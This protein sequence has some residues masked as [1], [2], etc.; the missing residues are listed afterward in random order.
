MGE[1][2]IAVGVTLRDFEP[3]FTTASYLIGGIAFA[4]VLYWSYFDRALKIWERSL[5][6]QTLK[7]AGRFAVDVYTFT[8][9]ALIIG[10]VFS[11]VAMEEVFLHP[12]DPLEPFV[13]GLLTLAIACFFGGIAAAAMRANRVFLYERLI[14]IAASAAVLFGLTTISA[15]SAVL[16]VTAIIAIPMVFEHFRFRHVFRE[17]EAGD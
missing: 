9:F 17:V 7:T 16:L 1:A 6:R 3:S 11:A 5:A 8:H 10:I 12:N 14:A 2:I 15:K 4:M 13:A